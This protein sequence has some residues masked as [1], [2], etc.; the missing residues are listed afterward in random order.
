[1]T[2]SASEFTV[3]CHLRSSLVVDPV[4]ATVE[5]L[6]DLEDEG[7]VDSLLLRSW[8]KEVALD[9]QGPYLELLDRYE[10]FEDWADRN[11]VSV[12]PPFEVRSATSLASETERGVLVTPTICLAC[13]RDDRLAAVFPH[14]TDEGTYTVAEAVDELAAGELPGPVDAEVADSDAAAASAGAGTDAV[15]A[16]GTG[17]GDADE[18]AGPATASV[19]LTCPSCD[20]ELVNVQGLLS[21]A[22]CRWSDAFL[23]D[24][25]SP[26][27][28]LVYLSLSEE[29]VSVD[30]LRSTL[31]VKK[32]TLYSILRT[33]S[34]RGLVEQT[35]DDT[36]RAR[37][38]EEVA[39]TGGDAG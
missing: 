39:T 21:C 32:S 30:A 31:D 34:D 14:E 37:R 6:R 26:G 27:A 7:I 3:A 8:P 18:E 17:V 38:R 19:G 9:A 15:A 23:T 24:I 1:M 29:P 2:A 4:N 28:K 11:G 5:R 13:Y 22:D 36:Y 10:Q 12:R 25:T 33:L 20:G 35:D 16:E